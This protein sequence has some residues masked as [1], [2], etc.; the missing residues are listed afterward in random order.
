M[1]VKTG[2][3]SERIEIHVPESDTRELKLLDRSDIIFAVIYGILFF[4]GLIFTLITL[5]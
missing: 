5:E 1:T 3:E 2:S 4:W